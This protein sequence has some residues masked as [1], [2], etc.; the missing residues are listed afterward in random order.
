MPEFS[1]EV[2]RKLRWR[3]RKAEVLP[4]LI[5]GGFLVAYWLRESLGLPSDTIFYYSAAF[6]VFS[7]FHL[8][9]RLKVIQFRLA[10]MHDRLDALAGL[11]Y[12]RR[13]RTRCAVP[14]CRGI[15]DADATFRE[16]LW[17]RFFT[18]APRPRTPSELLYSDRRL[19][20]KSS[21]AVTILIRK[22]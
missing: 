3:N 21:P 12:P 16:A 22:R 14:E 11:E 5:L 4:L 19:R 18:A 17:D 10:W 15:S 13:E 7:F 20:S 2:R 1:E 6:V 8:E 9:R